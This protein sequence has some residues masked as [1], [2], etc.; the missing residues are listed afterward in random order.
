MM[1]LKDW[2]QNGF[3]GRG[4][5][6]ATPHLV[7]RGLYLAISHGPA[8]QLLVVSSAGQNRQ[9]GLR[10]QGGPCLVGEASFLTRTPKV[11]FHKQSSVFSCWHGVSGYWPWE[12]TSLFGCGGGKW[13]KP[14]WHRKAQSLGLWEAPPCFLSPRPLL[15]PSVF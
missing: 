12:L 15:S 13:L 5:P 8:P 2:M 9:S 11:T 7:E 3:G 6:S 4:I 10:C 14:L 1:G